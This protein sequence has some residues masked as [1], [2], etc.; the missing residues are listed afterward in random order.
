MENKITSLITGDKF[1]QSIRMVLPKHCSP[2]RFTRIAISATTRNPL[3]AQCEPASVMKCLMDLSQYGIEPD[4]RRAH[5][6]PF[7]NNKRNCYECTLILDYKG[8][9]ELVMR[10]GLV[11]SLHADVVCDNDE[12]DYNCGRIEKHR[13]DFRKPRGPVYASYAICRLKDGTEKCDVMSRDEIES[14]RQRSRSGDSGPWVTDWSEM[15][16]KTVFKRLSKWLPLTPEVQDAVEK[17]D[18]APLPI[19]LDIPALPAESHAE[20]PIFQ[21]LPSEPA[22]RRGRPPKDLSQ[23]TKEETTIKTPQT[24]LAEA[25]DAAGYRYEQFRVIAT[26]LGIEGLDA[27][28]SFEDMTTDST[29]RCLKGWDAIKNG[30][31]EAKKENLL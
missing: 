5:L 18:E 8:I 14:I 30:L 26:Q 25:V 13:I 10:T 24:E 9:A 19:D 22:K 4:G 6:I 28:P 20:A 11:S 17:D 2:D 7:K 15:A 21:P 23:P 3:L 12:F 31:D 27:V 29:V 1:R 16:K